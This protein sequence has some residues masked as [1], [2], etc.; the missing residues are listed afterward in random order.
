MIGIVE[1]Q[2]VPPQLFFKGTIMA[3]QHMPNFLE[4]RLVQGRKRTHLATGTMSD[5]K[6]LTWSQG[7]ELGQGQGPPGT[8]AAQCISFALHTD[9]VSWHPVSLLLP[10]LLS[11]D[12]LSMVTTLSILSAFPGSSSPRPVHPQDP[13]LS[14]P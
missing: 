6:D 5:C 7:S 12:H 4:G 2:T 9:L 8:D 13:T 1:G 14:P 11:P 10:A 3:S